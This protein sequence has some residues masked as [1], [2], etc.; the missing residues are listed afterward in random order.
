MFLIHDTSTYTLPYTFVTLNKSLPVNMIEQNEIKKHF[1]Q[2]RLP[3]SE[4]MQKQ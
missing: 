2:R 1:T 3:E 4:H